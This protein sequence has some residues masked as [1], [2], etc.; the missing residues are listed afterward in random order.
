MAIAGATAGARHTL[1]LAAAV[2]RIGLRLRLDSAE[3]EST[4]GGHYGNGAD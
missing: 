3:S 2:G 4:Q 1:T